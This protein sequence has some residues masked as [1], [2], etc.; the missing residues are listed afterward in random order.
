M[1]LLDDINLISRLDNLIRTK[2]TGNPKQLSERLGVS[3]RHTYRLINELKNMGFP[4]EYSRSKDSYCYKGDVKIHFEIK[5]DEQ[6]VLN[7]RGGN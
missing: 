1:K 7:V 6:K 3:E 4:V 5:V 2:A